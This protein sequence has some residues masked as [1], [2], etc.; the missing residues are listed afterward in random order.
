MA[1]LQISLLGP[2]QAVMDGQ[3][4][5]GFESNKVRALLAY[6]AVK[7]TDP[8]PGRLLPVCCGPI[9]PTAPPS[10]I[11]DPHCPIY[12]RS[13][14]T[15]TLIPRSCSFP[16]TPSSS[17]PL[18]TIHWTSTHCRSC[19]NVRS[20]NWSKPWRTIGA[21]FWRGSLCPTAH[22]SR[23]GFSSSANIFTGWF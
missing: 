11:Y 5:T 10:A 13:S 9:T 6:L 1:R 21:A 2:Y 14:T 22:P 12:V 3:P 4:V 7:L 15:A 16:A 18:A 20:I 23:I 17:T 19:P 8:T